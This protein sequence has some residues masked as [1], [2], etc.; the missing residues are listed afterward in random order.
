MP[1]RRD[2]AEILLDWAL[3]A[4]NDEPL[5][6]PKRFIPEPPDDEDWIERKWREERKHQ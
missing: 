3:K 6:Q 5:V 4:L 1:D 2:P